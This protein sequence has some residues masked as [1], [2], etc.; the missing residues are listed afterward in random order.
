MRCATSIL[1]A[2]IEAL[3]AG[4]TLVPQIKLLLT[5]ALR[6]INLAAGIE[7]WTAGETLVHQIEL[8]RAD[9]LRNTNLAAGIGVR[10]DCQAPGGR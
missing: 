8:L 7:D 6:Y 1:A 3:E 10:F 2:G 4:E 9:A 5:D